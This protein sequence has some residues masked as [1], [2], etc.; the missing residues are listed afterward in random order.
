MFDDVRAFSF[1]LP[2]VTSR[3]EAQGVAD[4]LNELNLEWE[5]VYRSEQA[6]MAFVYTIAFSPALTRVFYWAKAAF[7]R[8]VAV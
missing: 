4:A 2:G 7:R 5:V 3:D 8:M 1:R 6:A